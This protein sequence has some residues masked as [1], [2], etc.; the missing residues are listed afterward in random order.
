MDTLKASTSALA[1]SDDA[2]YTQIEDGI[3]SL[4]TQRDALASQIR[5][6]LND[7]AFSNKQLDEKQAKGWIDQ[8]QSLIDQA[9]ALSSD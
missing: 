5:Q 4:T 3:A 1:S 7:A 6:A 9:K 2:T 8:A